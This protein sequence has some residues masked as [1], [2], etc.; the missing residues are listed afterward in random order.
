MAWRK[1]SFC[2]I[3]FLLIAFT[4]S[5]CGEPPPPTPTPTPIPYDIDVS[6][7]DSDGNPMSGVKVSFKTSEYETDASGK[8][9]ISNESPTA[10]LT[11]SS[12]GYFTTEVSPTLQQGSTTVEVSLESDPNGLLPV[13]GC[14][15]NEELIFLQDFQDGKFDNWGFDDSSQGWSIVANPD[16]AE[17]QVL[18][19]SEEAWW[20]WL[21]GENGYDLDNSVWRIWYKLS[22]N[23][24][25]HFNYRFESQVMNGSRYFLAVNPDQASM[26]R[27]QNE[28][29]VDINEVSAP[30]PSEWHLLE[31][32]YYDGEVQVWIDHHQ[33]ITF[34]EESPWEGGTVNLEPYVGGGGELY[35]DD[36]SLC[37]LNAPFETIP[38]PETGYDLTVTAMDA[39]G[40]PIAYTSATVVEMGTDSL[41][42]QLSD[43][44]GSVSWED[45][46]G[47]TATVQVSAPG[48]VSQEVTQTIEKDTLADLTI[49]LELDE[50][51]M[52][53]SIACSPNESLLYVDDIQD[54]NLQGWHA[55]MNS[56]KFNVPGWSIAADP[57]DQENV[58]LISEY[59]GTQ[60]SEQRGLEGVSFDDGVLRFWTKMYGDSHLL[61]G[62]HRNDQPFMAGETPYLYGSY[63]SFI[64]AFNGG[65]VERFGEPEGS[66]WFNLQT[67]GWTYGYNGD[68]KWHQYEISTYQGEVQIWR[69]GKLLGKWTDPEPISSGFFTFEMDFW[70][71]QGK[72]YLDD[73]SVCGLSAPFETNYQGPK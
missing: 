16:N 39:E 48:Y 51:G 4:L 54:S 57:D 30:A 45:L 66:Q 65:R 20:A 5:G 43:E 62:W 12:P 34:T 28:S 15:V 40:L 37:K 26:V 50:A 68:G 58:I 19:A 18:S 36:L 29:H 14:S 60:H 41:A 71:P 1:T 6:V 53:A 49:T 7:T 25:L 63:M 31:F 3:L 38:R 2:V 17:D 52:P 56:L 64:Y 8:V 32:S 33:Q 11:V 27:Y 23:T 21:G 35:F 69:D 44:N 59:N 10:K 61:V 9:S 47:D 42:T 13:N 55:L 24:N 72:V 22:G 73:F 46:P 70:N 67:I